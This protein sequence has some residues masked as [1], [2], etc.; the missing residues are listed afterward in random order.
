MLRI[1]CAE[2]IPE[3]NAIM[4]EPSVYAGSEW[5]TDGAP[6]DIS[7]FLEHGLV[8]MAQGGCF[9]LHSAGPKGLVFHTCFLPGYRGKHVRDAILEMMHLIFTKTGATELLTSTHVQAKAAQTMAN[10]VNLRLRI[11]GE[12]HH[13]WG[14]TFLEW[15]SEVFHGPM[16]DRVWAACSMAIAGGYEDKAVSEYARAAAVYGWL[17]LESGSEKEAAECLR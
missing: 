3:I 1:A 4:N 14:I 9:L 15:A 6:V 10:W 12:D 8:L 17:P 5:P 16:R 2:D 7:Q 13:L 11:H